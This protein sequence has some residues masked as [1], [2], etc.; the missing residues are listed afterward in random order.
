M[1]FTIGTGII[2]RLSIRSKF[3]FTSPWF[4]KRRLLSFSSKRYFLFAILALIV[5]GILVVTGKALMSLNKPLS[6]T[7]V[8]IKSARATIDLN[9]NIQ[10]P[11]LDGKGNVVTNIAYTIGT[12]E[13]RDEII[14]K[15]RPMVAVKG[16]VF[17][18]LNIKLVNQYDKELEIKAR[19]YVRLSV[20]GDES[21]LLAPDIHNDPVR[22]QPI[23]TKNTRVGFPIYET[24]RNIVL[25]VGPIEKEKEKIPISFAL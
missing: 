6:D 15:N 3:H 14:V 11:V 13:V 12:A 24:D 9:K 22:V 21:E 2:D 4:N 16:R 7:R 25:L 5:I 8:Q 10:I 17:L 19:D 18:I 1:A 23:S 20:N